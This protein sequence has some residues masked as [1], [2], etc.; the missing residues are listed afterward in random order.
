MKSKKLCWERVQEKQLVL[1]LL[2]V[3]P[4]VVNQL[5]KSMVKEPVW[6][7]SSMRKVA[8]VEWNSIHH[9]VLH[10]DLQLCCL[11]DLQKRLQT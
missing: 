3:V 9:F 1:L 8:S 10:F 11:E 6:E 5:R 7:S 4:L 2:L